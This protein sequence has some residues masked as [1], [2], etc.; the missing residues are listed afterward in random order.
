MAASLN[1]SES[2]LY[3]ESSLLEPD[4]KP[5]PVRSLLCRF[6][7]AIPSAEEKQRRLRTAN[8]AVQIQIIPSPERFEQ[9]GPDPTLTGVMHL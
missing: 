3:T 8:G 6:R 7:A 1:P 9:Y 5:C 4:L 2:K